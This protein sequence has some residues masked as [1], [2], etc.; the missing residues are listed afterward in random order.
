MFKSQAVNAQ[1][2]QLCVSKKD[3]GS[4]VTISAVTKANPAVVSST[5]AVKVG[6]IV[7]FGSVTGMP[8]IDGK[9]A[10]VTKITAGTSFEVNIDA[11]GYAA[12][13]TAGTATVQ[14][15]ICGCETK[16][17]SG[18]DGS[19]AEVD[20]TTMCSTARE[21]ISGLQDFGSFSFDVNLVPGDEFQ[22]ELN[23]AKAA[24]EKRTFVL[25][26]PPD[27]E[28]VQY[29][30]VFDAFVRSFSISGGVDQAL[31]GS[32]SLRVTGEPILVELGTT[33]P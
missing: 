2:S 26:I 30:Y 32:V 27:N 11:S 21:Y 33:A 20:V 14:E 31:S 16:S 18:F 22:I 7:K 19:S 17:Y 24:L 12:A 10:V 29:A 1:G 8:E 25:R 4:A 3:G 15:L 28:G 13:G 6:D 23:K 9:L 5:D